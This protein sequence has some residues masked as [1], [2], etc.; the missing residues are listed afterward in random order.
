MKKNF[1]RAPCAITATV[2][3]SLL[4]VVAGS[5]PSA[6]KAQQPSTAAP[7]SYTDVSNYLLNGNAVVPQQSVAV[8]TNL[9]STVTQIGQMN[10]ATA[11]L[12]GSGNITIQYQSG[13]QNTSNLSAN[14]TQN[15]LTTTQVG[16]NNT[17][18]ISVNGNNN[19]VTNLQVGSGLTYQL[20]IVG[21]NAP[22]SVQQ[23]GRR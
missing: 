6:V 16:N 3:I 4:C 2:A 1:K 11:N 18:N 7:N 19:S 22:V 20:Q 13:S 10:N 8:S 23:Y 5:V 14:G 15:T 17:S 9:S 21:T 12:A